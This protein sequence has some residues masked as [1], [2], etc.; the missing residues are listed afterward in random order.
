MIFRDGGR[1]SLLAV[2]RNGAGVYVATITMG[3]RKS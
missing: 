3:V 1:R 2:K